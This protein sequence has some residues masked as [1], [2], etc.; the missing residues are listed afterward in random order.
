M[1]ASSARAYGCVCVSIYARVLLYACIH[2]YACE[3]KTVLEPFQDSFDSFEAAAVDRWTASTFFFARIPRVRLVS[4]LFRFFLFFF[5]CLLFAFRG[6]IACVSWNVTSCAYR[7]HM[8]TERMVVLCC[9]GCMH[10]Y[11]RKA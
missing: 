3:R 10:V 7:F 9:C 1:Y 4:P 8:Y 2:V 6:T 5:L 11:V